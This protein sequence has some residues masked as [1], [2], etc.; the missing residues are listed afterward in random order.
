MK[1]KIAIIGSG[2]AGLTLANFLFKDKKHD[3]MV[4]E[5]NESQQGWFEGIYNFK[6]L[7]LINVEDLTLV[8]EDILIRGDVFLDND[9]KV[10]KIN[11][12]EFKRELDNFSANINFEENL[13][14]PKML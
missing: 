2:I 1:K 9:R 7:S 6:N 11:I 5:K 4:Y 8:T 10:N 12:K 14:P 13:T 3:F